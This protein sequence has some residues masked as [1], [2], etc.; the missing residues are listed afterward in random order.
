MRWSRGVWEGERHL[1]LVL[2]FVRQ[3]PP[4]RQ[5]KNPRCK[6]IFSAVRNAVLPIFAADADLHNSHRNRRFLPFFSI[7]FPFNHCQIAGGS[8]GGLL[9]VWLGNRYGT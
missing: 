2:R 4:S 3:N 9:S 8:G 7:P 1:V 5:Q 6:A